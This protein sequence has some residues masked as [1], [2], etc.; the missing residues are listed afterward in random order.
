MVNGPGNIDR[1]L[2]PWEDSSVDIIDNVTT[3]SATDAL[4]ANMG[5]ELNRSLRGRYWVSEYH[6]LV[7]DVA[8][9]S[10]ELYWCTAE[11]T[12]ASFIV[13][14]WNRLASN[15][16]SEKGGVAFTTNYL[17]EVGDIVT[18]SDGL[19]YVCISGMTTE[20][21]AQDP[22]SSN[23]RV[24]G[25]AEK[26]GVLWS[27]AHD[28]IVGDVVGDADNIY[29]CIDNVSSAGTRPSA[30]GVSWKL[31]KAAELGGVA[32]KT[33]TDYVIGDIVW[34]SNVD[35]AYGCTTAHNSGFTSPASS[36]NWTV[37]RVTEVAGRLW[38][39]IAR[40]YLAGD[41]VSYEH[42]S[43][44]AFDDIAA[45]GLNLNPIAAPSQWRQVEEKS[46][47]MYE[48]SSEYYEG[49]LVTENSVAYVCL[50]AGPITGI[51]PSTSIGVNWGV[52]VPAEVAGKDFNPNADYAIGDV[53]TY[54]SGGITRLYV[55][56]EVIDGSLGGA[57]NP[58]QWTEFGPERGGRLWS[59]LLQYRIG[60]IVIASDGLAY[61]AV[62][63][64]LNDNP[65]NEVSWKELG[66][67]IF[68]ATAGGQ[69]AAAG[70]TFGGGG[71]HIPDPSKNNNGTSG[72]VL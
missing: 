28:Y 58:V 62:A 61:S 8:A 42:K 71:V 37:I 27:S 41:I 17:Y 60:D 36:G 11:N 40:D 12:D 24:V 64:S 10:G 23:W 14:K 34:D 19:V 1:A 48:A 56:E 57:F 2:Y 68:T 9:F 45:S 20:D 32:W 55:G 3:E 31:S 30:N 7:G 70:I 52:L 67:E 43:F 39:G 54:L 63:D 47:T 65:T 6:Y 59:D 21:G 49:E 51:T 50:V 5:Y 18:Y 53:V 46:G 16:A 69:D 13:S 66:E 26:G 4:S 33:E 35:T 29:V 44:I 15:V 72:G 25:E 22:G 38:D